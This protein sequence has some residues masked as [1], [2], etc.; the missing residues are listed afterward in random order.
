[1]CKI[2][3]RIKQL[4]TLTKHNI[5]SLVWI[6]TS[7]F[8]FVGLSVIGNLTIFGE[9][10]HGPEI[11]NLCKARKPALGWLGLHGVLMSYGQTHSERRPVPSLIHGINRGQDNEFVVTF[12]TW[13]LGAFAN[14]LD[15]VASRHSVATSMVEFKPT[16]ASM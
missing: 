1:M 8:I 6:Y 4:S 12:I 16:Q 9:R 2:R 15:S 10:K 13:I 5:L 11:R 7:F 14:N 3:L